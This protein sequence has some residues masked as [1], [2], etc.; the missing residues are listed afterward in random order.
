MLTIQHATSISSAPSERTMIECTSLS[1]P[2]LRWVYTDACGHEHRWTPTGEYSPQRTYRLPSCVEVADP[3]EWTDEGD[4][5][6]LSH[7]ECAQCGQTIEPGYCP[8]EYQTFIPG[9][10]RPGVINVTMPAN[11][12]EAD[13]FLAAFLDAKPADLR[14]IGGT[15]KVIVRSW[16]VET[17]GEVLVVLLPTGAST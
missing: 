16:T 8:D 4:E 13:A 6:H 14:W 11:S 15:T 17:D 3:S 2:D 7:F 12:F 1:R 10:L 9:L 5:I